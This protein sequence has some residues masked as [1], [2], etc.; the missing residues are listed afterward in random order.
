MLT[1]FSSFVLQIGN[2]QLVFS[3]RNRWESRRC[4]V[5][6]VH[7]PAAVG[8]CEN[9]II[10]E[11]LSPIV[12]STKKTCLDHLDTLSPVHYDLPHGRSLSPPDDSSII[13]EWGS[14]KGSFRR[15]VYFRYIRIF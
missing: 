15:R 2:R 5:H 8:N 9:E 12:I 14:I 11:N 10:S 1:G 4:Y 7:T 13:A 3:V 6:I